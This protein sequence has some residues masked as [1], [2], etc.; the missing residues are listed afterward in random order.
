MPDKITFV[1]FDSFDKMKFDVLG[2]KFGRF[3]GENAGLV[4][5]TGKK[6]EVTATFR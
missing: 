4:E 1:S 2:E 3:I 5:K 6:I